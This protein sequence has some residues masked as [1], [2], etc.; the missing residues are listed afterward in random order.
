MKRIPKQLA[1]EMVLDV[2]SS[3]VRLPDVKPEF[4]EESMKIIDNPIDNN[5]F[6]GIL[7]LKARPKIID[8]DEENFQLALASALA[9]FVKSADDDEFLI[10]S[11]FDA[12]FIETIQKERFD[13]KLEFALMQF[14]QAWR[15]YGRLEKKY[16]NVMEFM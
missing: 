15:E 10:K 13:S 2:L 6:S 14:V 4:A 12:N 1:E 8:Q 5:L 7:L 16:P 11:G 3:I 9:T